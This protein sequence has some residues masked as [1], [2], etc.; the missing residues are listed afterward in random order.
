MKCRGSFAKSPWKNPSSWFPGDICAVMRKVGNFIL[1][2]CC[3]G[4]TF[5]SHQPFGCRIC[6]KAMCKVDGFH[7]LS[8]TEEAGKGGSI[9][10]VGMQVCEKHTFF[11]SPIRIIRL[12]N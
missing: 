11:V 3:P 8:S 4:E 10:C 7:S 12:L 6:S 9:D 5:L 2:C 1:P